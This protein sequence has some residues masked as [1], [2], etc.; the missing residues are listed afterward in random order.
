MAGLC[1]IERC[2][3]KGTYEL[4]HTSN[5]RLC[6]T[7]EQEWRG[8]GRRLRANPKKHTLKLVEVVPPTPEPAT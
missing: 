1:D 2:N 4:D 8:S 7:H 6:E 3:N 5:Y